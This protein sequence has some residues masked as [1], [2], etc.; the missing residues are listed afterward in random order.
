MVS[1]KEAY[2]NAQDTLKNAD[3]PSFKIDS[4]V[5]TEHILGIDSGMLTLYL[6][7]MLTEEEISLLEE[8]IKKRAEDIPL[9]YITRK[10]EF[11]SLPFYVEEGVL[12][13]R[14]DTEIL[15]EEALKI[16]PPSA[17][18][19]D[20]CC[21]SGCIGLTLAKNLPKS[22]VTLF[23]ISDIAISVTEKNIENLNIKNAKSQKRDILSEELPEN[24]DI[25]VSNPPYI[26]AS[27][28]ATLD[29]T[30]KEYEPKEALTDG[31]DGLLFYK[32]LKYLSD[33]YLK[34]DGI[35]LAEIGINQLN[36]VKN[37]FG[38]I[39]Y[40]EDLSGIPRV[41]KYKKEE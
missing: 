28:I 24:Y 41:I 32:R 30:V 39:H 7:K 26:P 12:I 18:I 5:L 37:I 33:N 31:G 38:K 19:A 34:K 14:N 8:L 29:K 17:K 22:E 11:Y 1:V 6:D 3:I 23:D 16:S 4:R 35:L 40:T 2:K 10:K 20:L 25:I 27:D 21:G 15:V 13:P 9:S 36:D